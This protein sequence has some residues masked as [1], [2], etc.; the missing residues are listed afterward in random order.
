VKHATI[1]QVNVYG[2][3]T[4]IGDCK[5][6]LVRYKNWWDYLCFWPTCLQNLSA[7]CVLVM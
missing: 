5:G 3:V 4:G 1:V 2:E 7:C 6:F